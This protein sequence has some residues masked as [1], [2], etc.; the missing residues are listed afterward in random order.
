MVYVFD[1]GG[2]LF[3]WQPSL[4]LRHALPAHAHDDASTASWVERFFEGYQGDWAALDRGDVD[5]PEAVHRIARRTGLAPAEVRGVVDAV[6]DHL[7]LKADTV[8]LIARLRAAGQ[9]VGFLSNMSQHFADHL[10]ALHPLE[11]WFNA[12]GLFSAE[13]R[14]MKPDP[15]IFALAQQRFG[16]PAQELMFFDDHPANITAAR[17][18]GW[19]ALQ[20]FDAAQAEAALRA[21]GHWPVGA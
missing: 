6:A 14:C 2:V 1:F 16:V 8:A 7:H 15:A 20:F 21:A 17:A 3:Q 11:D 5:V 10:R 18:A 19:Q 9:A 12:G 4:L 13:V